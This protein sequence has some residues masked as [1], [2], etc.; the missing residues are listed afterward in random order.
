MKHRSR[1]PEQD[2]LLR[3]R[4]VDMIDLRHE[5][6][7]LA[8]LIDWEVFEREWAGFFPSATGRPA[9]SPRLVAGLLYRQ[10]AYRLSDEAVVARW[11]ETPYYQHFTGE[12]F[13]QHR[14]PIDPSS[15]TRWRGRI[16][17]EGVEWL[18]TQTIRA[19]QKSGAID[20][21]SVKRVAVD[22]TVMEKAIAH[23]TDA[24]LYERARDQ[25]V[26]LARGA[27]VELRQSYAR[28]AP[29]LAL[30]VGRYAH[31]KQFKR[32]RKALK[33]LKGY[34]GRVMRDLRRHLGD[35]P[36]GTLRDGIVAKLALVSQL[37]HQQPKGSDKIYALHEPEVDCISKGKAR[38]RYEFGC[39]VSVATT[40]DEGFVVGMRSFPGNPYDGHTLAP[41]LEQVEILTDQRSGLAV[42]DRGYRGH[43]VAAT[44]VLISG[45][46][47]GLTPKLIADL[48]RRGAI[49]AEIGHMKTDG[50]LARCPLK[51][52]IGDA[53]FAV[54][55]ACG[56][57]I[58]KILAHLRAWLV[59]IIATI[60][61]AM[62]RPDRPRQALT[63]A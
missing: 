6:V 24:R 16:G 12:V 7:K 55:C 42:V 35:I 38:V 45:T 49:E 9:T 44:R 32:M 27:G 37:L 2:D 63:A 10:H 46:R 1:P 39:K 43:G 19:G 13:F 57:N 22:T 54:L 21:D 5:L 4:L 48:R 18:L 25:L 50:R 3:P 52:T 26:A 34:T 17:E 8:A 60:L 62:T 15:L 40:L 41:A 33:K 31:A 61:N 47:R 11:V 59:L 14:P 51:G 56:H 20:E 30:Q 58:R 23:P 28:L 36:E 53:L 29:R